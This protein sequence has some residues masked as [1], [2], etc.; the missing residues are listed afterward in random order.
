MSDGGMMTVVERF[1]VPVATVSASSESGSTTR[2]LFAA[3]SD[4]SF[5]DRL[6]ERGIVALG[7]IGIGDGKVGDRGIEDRT[8]ADIARDRRRIA[9]PRMGARQGE[10]AQPRIKAQR[11]F[12]D[13][14]MGG[15]GRVIGEKPLVFLEGLRK[16]KNLPFKNVH[17]SADRRHHYLRPCQRI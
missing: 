4:S 14:E 15:A 10:V 9:R 13:L 6:L 7:L 11:L 3:R 1:S 8:G 2:D 12:L 5:L 17:G 16:L